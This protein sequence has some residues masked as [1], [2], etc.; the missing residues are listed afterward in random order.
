M[1]AFLV[2]ALGLLDGRWDEN[3]ATR[4]CDA[5]VEMHEQ[6][7]EWIVGF[8]AA[9]V[10]EAQVASAVDLALLTSRR[11]AILKRVQDI[12]DGRERDDGE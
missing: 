1:R 9:L 4:F 10:R 7:H 5:M 12:V 2:D 8:C 3:T 6:G 11:D